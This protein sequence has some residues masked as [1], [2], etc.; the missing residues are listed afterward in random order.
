[1]KKVLLIT[2]LILFFDQAVKIFIKTHFEMGESLEIFSWFFLSFVENPGMAYG[3]HLGPGYTGKI[4]LSCLRLFLS[5]CF[6]LWIYQHC[7]KGA[8]NYFIVPMSMIFA[9]AIGNLIDSTFYGLIFD[10]GIIFDAQ[11]HR[12]LGYLG[13]ARFGSPGYSFFM[14]GAVVDMLYFPIIDDYWPKWIPY[15]GGER[16]EFFKPVFNLADAF[17][18]MGGILMIIFGDKVFKPVDSLKHL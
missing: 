17:I 6:F 11:H 14:G 7:K 10:R 15:F 3:L 12:W 4:I 2:C 1:L 18:S 5:A 16:F 8:S 13:V 9:G